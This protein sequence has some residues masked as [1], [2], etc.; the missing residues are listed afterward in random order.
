MFL[1][2]IEEARAIYLSFNGEKNVTWTNDE[3][4]ILRD[5]DKLRKSGLAHPLMAEIEQKLMD[6]G[7][8]ALGR[9]E[10]DIKVAMLSNEERFAIVLN[11]NELETAALLIK[12]SRLSEAKVIYERILTNPK[13]DPNSRRAP[14]EGLTSLAEQFFARGH[15]AQ[16]IECCDVAALYAPER[17][18][19]QAI[20]AHALM[21]LRSDEARSA[22]L[23]NRGKNFE[24]K[25]WEASVL[26]DFNEFRINGRGEP[27][28]VEIEQI[29]NVVKQ[30]PD[31]TN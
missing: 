15:L 9:R 28:M 16:A 25:S 19:L 3:V 18:R 14:L 30:A 29:F 6:A 11:D 17:Y 2:K 12:A 8:T 7:W 4:A 24:G 23:R 22:Y 20:R 10:R 27:L 31:E 1:E 26:Q 5:F 13:I 21:F